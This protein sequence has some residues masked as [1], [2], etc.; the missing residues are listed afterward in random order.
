MIKA[1]SRKAIFRLI[2]ISGSRSPSFRMDH[3][4]LLSFER[5]STAPGQ[6]FKEEE[7]Q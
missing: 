5:R 1:L 7:R 6:F 3:P 4:R 2:V